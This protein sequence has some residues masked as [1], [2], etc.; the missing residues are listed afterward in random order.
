MAFS[1]S[2]S[3]APR[4]ALRTTDAARYLGVSASLL[5]KMRGRGPDDPLGTGP[6]YIRLSPSLI[7]YEITA[8]DSWLD[9]HEPAGSPFRGTQTGQVRDG[10][11]SSG[12]KR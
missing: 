7:V 8:L 5:R 2:T 10:A 11:Q 12:Q 9:S 1:T 3:N 6:A 4:R